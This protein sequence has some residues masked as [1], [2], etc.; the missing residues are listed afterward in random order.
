MYYANGK[1]PD[2]GFYSLGDRHFIS[3]IVDNRPAAGKHRVATNTEANRAV[4]RT[5]L[6]GVIQQQQA[7]LLSVPSSHECTNAYC[8]VDIARASQLI[9]PDMAST[10]D[11]VESAA[12][13][14]R[15]RRRRRADSGTLG[16]T[17]QADA[18]RRGTGNVG[19]T[20]DQAW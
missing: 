1:F 16:D 6:D 10:T 15:F 2:L 5:R 12:C 4:R 20:S 17:E 9:G 18:A 13:T 3:H 8:T 19:G 14:S 11:I 7:E